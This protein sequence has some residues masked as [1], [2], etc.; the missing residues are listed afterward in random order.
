[1]FTVSLV[2]SLTPVYAQPAKVLEQTGN[3]KFI[4]D[5][6]GYTF[7][8]MDNTLLQPGYTVKTG[9]DGYAKFQVPD[10]STFEVFPNS[11]VVYVKSGSIHE[12]LNVW[13]GKVKVYIQHLP[14]VPNPNTVTTPTALISVRGTIFLV[15]VEDMD[16]TTLVSLDEGLVVVK[17]RLKAGNPLS[18][19]PGQAIKVYPDQP[20]AALRDRGNVL[21]N[22]A[23]VAER[24]LRDL[25]YTR[26]GGTN[27][28]GNVPT[29]NGPQGDKSNGKNGDNN[30]GTGSAPTAP[31]TGAAP[32]APT[33]PPGGGGGGGD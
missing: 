17:H 2:V 26:P 29:G 12:L 14:H 27:G 21:H 22:V 5:S 1:L 25:L 13:L 3:V 24:A 28:G 20:L 7:A 16:G 32:T 8:L 6:S 23:K 9:S 31:G 11:E 18:L 33:P 30:K 15:E 19:F 4:K 10:G